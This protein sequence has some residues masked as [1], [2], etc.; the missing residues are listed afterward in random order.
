MTWRKV[1]IVLVVA[2]L[3][4][5]LSALAYWFAQ[6]RTQYGLLQDY[7]QSDVVLSKLEGGV[8]RTWGVCNL[9][10]ENRRCRSL[11]IPLDLNKCDSLKEHL[12]IVN[13]NNWCASITSKEFR[14][15][16]IEI[17]LG[18]AYE[19]PGLYLELSYVE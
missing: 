3:I 4:V 13:K 5:P 11:L 18:S 6:S 14:G 16:T 1:L 12:D 10:G 7:K 2:I 19:K 9:D 17:R 15:H 8:S